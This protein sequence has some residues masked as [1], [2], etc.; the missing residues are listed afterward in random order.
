MNIPLEVLINNIYLRH[1]QTFYMYIVY[2][3][4][5]LGTLCIYEQ[6]GAGNSIFSDCMLICL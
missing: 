2:G 6:N 5:L 1:K 3:T 4:A